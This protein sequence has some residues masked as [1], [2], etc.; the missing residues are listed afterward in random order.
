MCIRA[1]VRACMR[2]S[3]RACVRACVCACVCVCVWG[4]GGG[5]NTGGLV[6]GTPVFNTSGCEIDPPAMQVFCFHHTTPSPVHPAF[7]LAVKWVP[8]LLLG[9]PHH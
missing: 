3:V 7:N 4:G 5:G 9:C 6:V 8:S 2:A 1:C